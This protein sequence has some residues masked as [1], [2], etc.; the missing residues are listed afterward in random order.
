[1]WKSNLIW[2]KVKHLFMDKNAI[3]TIDIK[4]REK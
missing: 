4:E 1:M 2:L 3:K